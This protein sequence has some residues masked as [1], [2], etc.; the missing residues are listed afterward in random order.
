MFVVF[1]RHIS[2]KNHQDFLWGKDEIKIEEN[3][4]PEY[5][6]VVHNE[7]EGQEDDD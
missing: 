2:L 4:E 6:Y 1:F 7:Q 5:E 3:E